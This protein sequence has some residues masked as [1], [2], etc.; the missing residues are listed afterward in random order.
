MI[1]RL[2]W[3]EAKCF[4]C[5]NTIHYTFK[6]QVYEKVFYFDKTGLNSELGNMQIGNIHWKQIRLETYFQI[7]NIILRLETR[8][9]DW[10]HNSQIGNTELRLETKFLDWKQ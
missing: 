3:K 2:S 9:L 6:L 10:K 5:R 8:F 1:L 7:G 4:G